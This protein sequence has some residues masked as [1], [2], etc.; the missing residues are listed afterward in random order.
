MGGQDSFLFTTAPNAASNV[1]VINDFNVADD[2]IVLNAAVF[3]AIGFGSVAGSQFVIGTGAEDAGDRIIYNDATGA[4][5][6]DSDGTGGAAAVQFAQ[7]SA[8]L[9]LTNFDFYVNFYF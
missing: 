5:Y 4:V 8:G 3:G 2:T 7:V 1:D 6:Y 9:P